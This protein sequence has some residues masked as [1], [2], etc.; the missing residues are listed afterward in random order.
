MAK[1]SLVLDTRKTSRKTDGT[2]PIALSVY[3]KDR[4]ISDWDIPPQF[5]AG[6]Q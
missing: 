6:M 1:V 5:L 3:H 4:D 2:Y